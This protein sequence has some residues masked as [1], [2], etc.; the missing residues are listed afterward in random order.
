MNPKFDI[1]NRTAK[2]ATALIFNV[3]DNFAKT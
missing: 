2:L 1:N 3:I